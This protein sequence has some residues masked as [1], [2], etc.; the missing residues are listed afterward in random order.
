MRMTIL[1]AILP[2]AATALF[3]AQAHANVPLM[4]PEWAAQACQAFNANSILTNGLGEKWIKNDGGRGYKVIHLYRDDCGEK[5]K[6]QMT[7]VPDG[8]NKARCSYGGK[9]VNPTLDEARD[10]KMWA[11]T[12]RWREMGAGEYGPMRAMMFNR[13]RF[14]GPKAEAM[15]VMGPF[16]QFLLLPGKVPGSDACPAAN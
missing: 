12:Q 2:I 1:P 13:L 16:E 9:V 7:I 8:T 10:Y 6:V 15:G 4:S 14:E 5:T 3:A 11:T